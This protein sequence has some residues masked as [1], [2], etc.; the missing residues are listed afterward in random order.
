MTRWDPDMPPEIDQS[1]HAYPRVLRSERETEVF[2]AP[3]AG[4]AFCDT[5]IYQVTIL[6]TEQLDTADQDWQGP[7]VPAQVQEGAL[8]FRWTFAG[9]QRHMLLVEQVLDEGPRKV[10]EFAVYSVADD[11]Y[12][13]TPFRG[14]LHMHSDRSDGQ[15]PPPH[16]A[17]MCRKIGM[18]FMAITDHGLY[19]PSLE[20]QR[21]FVNLPVDLRIYPGEEVHPPENPIHIVNFGGSFSINDLFLQ[22]EYERDT[23]A[24]Q[25]RLRPV[26]ANPYWYAS[27]VWCFEQI[28]LAGGLG[29]FCHPYWYANHMMRIPE[30]LTD[31]VLENQ[32]FDALE[33]ISGY[34]LHETWSNVLQVARYTSE[35]ERGKRI[36]IVGASDSHGTQRDLFG[37]Y[38]T[39]GW[40]YTLVFAPSADLPDLIASI[41]EMYSVAVEALPGQAL[42]V[43][44]PFRM[45]KYALFV[46]ESLMPAHDKLCASEGEQMLAHLAGDPQAAARLGL[47]QGQI[48]RLWQRLGCP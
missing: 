44:G 43:Y 5:A 38:H 42:H 22:P 46:L 23:Q 19:A 41:K 33:L 35:G 27:A 47:M 39:L 26:R 25:A 4:H 8:A 20:A 13:R 29:I 30:S 7:T 16:V 2:I 9:E 32:P 48:R 45:V 15:D 21:A 36:P 12:A 10:G 40:Y 1:Y 18:D 6:P 34:E 37:W 11:L 28:R 17:A 14:D 24:L 3:R 31:A